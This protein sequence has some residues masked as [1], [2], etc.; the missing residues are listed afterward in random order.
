MPRSRDPM[1]RDLRSPKYRPRVV[2]DRT[3]YDRKRKIEG[4]IEMGACDFYQN[5]K[6]KTAQEAFLN[7]VYDARYEY[8]HGGYTGTIAEKT[9]FKMEKLPEGV[10]PMDHAYAC[11]SDDNH[12]CQDKWGPAACI[13]LGNG[14]FLFFGSASS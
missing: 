13:D 10:D 4:D 11:M 12:F 2:R 8:G 3:K 1:A 9:S 6:G 7:A 14:E 5:A